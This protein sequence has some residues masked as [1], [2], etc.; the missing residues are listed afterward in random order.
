M[1]RKVTS[2]GG[3]H[4]A[5]RSRNN[6]EHSNAGS[7]RSDDDASLDGATRSVVRDSSRYVAVHDGRSAPA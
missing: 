6:A 3:T 5:V 1:L 7:I 4:G 2:D